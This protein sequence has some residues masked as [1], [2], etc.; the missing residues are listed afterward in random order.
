MEQNSCGCLVCLKEEEREQYLF[1][2][3]LMVHNIFLPADD[4]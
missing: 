1:L 4:F 3:Q 2:W